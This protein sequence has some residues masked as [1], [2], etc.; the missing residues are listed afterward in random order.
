MTRLLAAVTFLA[1]FAAAAAAFGVLWV[2]GDTGEGI[3]A[4]NS[5]E[6]DPVVAS[7][8]LGWLAL[9]ACLIGSFAVFK[10][11]RGAIGFFGAALLLAVLAC[12]FSL[13]TD[14]DEIEGAFALAALAA[15]PLAFAL[16]THRKRTE[17]GAAG[18]ARTG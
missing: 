1:G 16:L 13:G 5:T 15:V 14:L 6:R 8:I 3:S 12:T 18:A 9:A 10:H 17:R 11:A 2:L 7:A 4:S